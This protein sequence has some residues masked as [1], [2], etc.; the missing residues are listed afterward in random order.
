MPWSKNR[1]GSLLRK[2]KLFRICVNF[3]LSMLAFLW[4]QFEVRKR[5][6]NEPKNHEKK[7]NIYRFFDTLNVVLKSLA[8]VCLMKLKSIK[9][10]AAFLLF[11]FFFFII[12][13]V[14]TTRMVK[15]NTLNESM[16]RSD[17]T[18]SMRQGFF[19]WLCQVDS[20]VTMLSYPH[21]L[22]RPQNDDWLWHTTKI[23]TNTNT[24]ACIQWC[25]QQE[26]LSFC[27]W[28]ITSKSNCEK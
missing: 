12:I 10:C 28:K 19:I 8:E 6:W 14:C 11:F 2:D 15:L 21:I 20:Q 24:T 4:I 27:F 16:N 9:C 3:S 22:Q 25:V 26:E 13:I 5:E 7:N 18:S 1:F 17:T 23:D